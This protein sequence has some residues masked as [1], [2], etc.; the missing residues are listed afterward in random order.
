[1]FRLRD[2]RRRC[3]FVRNRR[4]FVGRRSTIITHS[5]VLDL[6]ASQSSVWLSTDHLPKLCAAVHR[7]T[8]PQ[9]D[10]L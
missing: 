6:V 8:E 10:S 4:G 9:T 3:P 5:S 2:W 7:L 1:M